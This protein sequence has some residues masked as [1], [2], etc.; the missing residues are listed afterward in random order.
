MFL[1]AVIYIA[2]IG[3]GLPDSI[4][5]TVWPAIYKEWNLPIS[6]GSFIITIV[7]CGTM[8]SSLMSAKVIKRF[9]T[10]NVTAFSTALTTVSILAFSYS[11]N[12]LM[13]CLCAIPLGL[14]AGSI[15]TALNNYVSIN[16]K[17]HHINFLHSFYGVGVVASPYIFSS[18][19]KKEGGWRKG[20]LIVCF[21]L[22]VITI[23]LFTTLFLWKKERK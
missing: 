3:L 13:L 21:I 17:A 5:G 7:Y 6:L 15:D 16:Y 8:V 22:A 4:F 1:L 10:G 20:Y 19:L 18:V 2:F 23:I 9:G 14:G 12:F 11:K